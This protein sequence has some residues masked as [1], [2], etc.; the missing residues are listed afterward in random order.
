M[1][2]I[3]VAVVMPNLGGG[4]VQRVLLNLGAE[5]SRRG[6]DVTVVALS[7]ADRG[8]VPGGLEVIELEEGGHVSRIRA[9][10][11]LCDE[12]GVDVIISGITRANLSALAAA[13][14]ARRRVRTVLT[15]H[16]PLDRLS[17]S[18]WRRFALRQVIRVSYSR[19]DAVVAVS[20]GTLDSLVAG[21]T[22]SA[23][24]L[25]IANPVITPDIEERSA[26]P[27]HHPWLDSGTP[28]VVL[29]AGR[30]TEQKGF[31]VLIRAFAELRSRRAARLVILGE[32]ELRE[33]LEALASTLGVAADV[34]L[35][36][37]VTDA[38]PY[39]ARAAVFALSS[40]WEGLPTVL[41]EALATGATVVAADCRVGP[42]EILAGGALGA[43]VPVD[44]P[45]ALAQALARALE[46]PKPVDRSV[47]AEYTVEHAADRYLELVTELMR[48]R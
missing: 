4:G 29:S 27:V 39:M 26:A 8:A 14:L 6:I 47:L 20:Q 48:E 5:F 10:A 21:G 13:R 1:N 18:A 36:G 32:G 44:D 9:L 23:R 3:S 41:I 40:R 24:L 30:L 43:L 31:D 42:R 7:R 45:A 28:P 22:R 33:D 12:R 11:A 37:H 34:S 15:K 17:R 46:G 19:A 38:L 16:L 2:E 25:R 35:P